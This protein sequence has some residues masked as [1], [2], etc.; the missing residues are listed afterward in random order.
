MGS[1]AGGRR[2]DGSDGAR[3]VLSFINAFNRQDPEALARVLD[4]EVVI[5]SV[6]GTRYGLEEALAWA[7]RVQTGELEQRIEI[8][9]IE[10]SGDRAV[11]LIRRQWWWRDGNELAREDEVAWGFELR[12]G[13]VRSW[14][15]FEDRAAALAE[16]SGSSLP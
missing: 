9:R 8:D 1:V 6:K 16:M 14:R 5:H 15:P 12:D 4:P 10:A 7:R 11:A 13:K 2:G 3:A